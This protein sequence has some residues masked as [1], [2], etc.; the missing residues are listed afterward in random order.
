MDPQTGRS[1]FAAGLFIVVTSLIMLPFQDPE[2]ASFIVTVL[3][4]GFGSAFLAVVIFM[5]RR[6][7]K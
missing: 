6:S 7:L 4:L 3:T 1:A 2:S 5:V